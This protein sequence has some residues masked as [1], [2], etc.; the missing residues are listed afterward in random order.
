[1]IDRLAL[2]LIIWLGG[3]GLTIAI[4]HIADRISNKGRE[5][6]MKRS[7]M[8]VLFA[9]VASGIMVSAANAEDL[10]FWHLV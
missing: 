4:F 5:G 2:V 6:T 8:R 10:T 3:V 9:F 1:M 7:R